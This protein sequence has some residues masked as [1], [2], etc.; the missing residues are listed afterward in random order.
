MYKNFGSFC[1]RPLPEE[2]FDYARA[3]THFLLY[4]FDNMR[5]ELI[6]RSNLEDP[7]RNKILDVLNKS[8]ETALQRYEHPIYD[9]ELG[10]GPVGWYRLISRTPVQYTRQQ[11]AVFKAVHK[12]RDDVA[13]EEDENP[14]F[15][16]PNHAVFSIARGLPKDKA[17]LY[18]AI[19]HVSHIVRARVDQLI[20]IIQKAKEEGETGPD[21][22]DTIKKIGDIKFPNKV[23]TIS[24]SAASGP[25]Q[26]APLLQ[27]KAPV[28]PLDSKV[29]RASSSKFWGSICPQRGSEDRRTV[30]TSAVH[31]ALPLPP[32]T[33]EIF[34][35]TNGV[36]S[37]QV[38]TEAA[39]PVFV[40]KEER[41][42]TDQGTDI[43][44]VKQLGGKRKR[45]RAEE[46]PSGTD[47]APPKLE[48]IE[49]DEIIL[50]EDEHE[51]RREA[52]RA[53][54]EAKLRKKQAANASGDKTADASEEP[55]FD[56]ANATS[57]LNAQAAEKKR[58]KGMK[59]KDRKKKDPGFNPY[60]QLGDAPRGLPRA[61]RESA[62]KTK[63]FSS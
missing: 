28:A 24:S 33:A 52:R 32:L 51:R 17:T 2:L 50:E 60:G 40:P 31:L 45:S 9:T 4:I 20:S 11:F 39:K 49:A 54:K 25:S 44:V 15:I 38:V 35:E 41:V 46:S 14:V 63:T 43:F 8:R 21:L 56:Y 59:K 30:S 58:E 57:V 62:G 12:W 47:S 61:Q 23:Q 26:S 1:Y 55:A 13:R 48:N 37:G 22:N 19:H 34:T 16:M 36:S 10:L 27:A 42:P 5:N 29:L 6:Q 53:K 7:D 18:T 3:D